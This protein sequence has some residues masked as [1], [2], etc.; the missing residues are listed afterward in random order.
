MTSTPARATGA[1]QDSNFTR[2]ASGLVREVCMWDALIMNTLG[3]NVAVGSVLLLPQ[4]TA[5]FRGGNMVLAVVIGTLIMAFTLLWVYSEFSAAMP[6]SGG[7]YVFV[8]RAL[9][10][11]L[12]WLLS[13]SQGIW[14]IFFWIGFNACFALVSAVPSAFITI[15][16]VTGG[17]GWVTA[18]NGPLAKH[19]FL[20]H[21]LQ[22]YI[23][24][25]VPLPNILFPAPL[26]FLL[27]GAP[28]VLL[29]S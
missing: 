4:S 11:F 12:G 27:P 3:M 28:P 25:F 22:G 29:P 23:F 5:I 26:L 2:S 24:L 17:H 9:P 6:R 1:P 16:S 18:A 7:D 19:H 10:P 13:W 20:G 21:H 14:L 15:G 8:S